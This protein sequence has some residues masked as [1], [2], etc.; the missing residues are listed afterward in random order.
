[1]GIEVRRKFPH[2]VLQC[3]LGIK[4][5]ELED[6]TLCKDNPPVLKYSWMVSCDSGLAQAGTSDKIIGGVYANEAIEVQFGDFAGRRGDHCSLTLNF[7][8]DGR[9]LSGADPRLRIMTELL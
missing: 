4:G 5:S 3:L 7:R 9:K 6:S 2:P 1:M 8:E